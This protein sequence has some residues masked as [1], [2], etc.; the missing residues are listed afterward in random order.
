M[1]WH[2]S[3]LYWYT[4]SNLAVDRVLV[5]VVINHWAVPVLLTRLWLPTWLNFW[6]EQQMVIRWDRATCTDKRDIYFKCLHLQ[7]HNSCTTTLLQVQCMHSLTLSLT[8]TY[9]FSITLCIHII[10]CLTGTCT[11]TCTCRLVKSRPLPPE[12]SCVVLFFK[13]MKESV[14]LCPERGARLVHHLDCYCHV[15]LQLNKRLWNVRQQ[16]GWLA[17]YCILC[18]WIY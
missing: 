15:A 16:L 8:L 5:G 2:C 17:F 11:Y 14:L 12:L 13:L 10:F 4:A 1:G 3:T 7:S 9:S 6:M 18:L